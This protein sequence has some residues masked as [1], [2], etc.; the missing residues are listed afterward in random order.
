MTRE[1][2]GT[3]W[4]IVDWAEG[5]RGRVLRQLLPGPRIRELLRPATPIRYL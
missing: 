3:S 1:V 4:S 2:G 5:A